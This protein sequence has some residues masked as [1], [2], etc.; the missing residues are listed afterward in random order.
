MIT[1][2]QETKFYRDIHLYIMDI[3][4]ACYT[5]LIK[6]KAGV[7]VHKLQLLLNHHLLATQQPSV[8]I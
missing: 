3:E 5:C 2:L 7:D 4:I 1:G 6:I 8:G